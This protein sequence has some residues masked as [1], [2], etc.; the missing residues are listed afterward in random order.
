MLKK[1]ILAAIL[2]LAAVNIFSQT[3]TLLLDDIHLYQG[4]DPEEIPY[5]S[6]LVG[7]TDDL[8]TENHMPGIVLAGGGLDNDDAMKW[9]LNRADGGDVVVI[10]S[11]STD[12]YNNYLYSSLGVTVN[13]VETILINSREAAEHPYVEE[14]IRNAEALFIAGGDQYDYYEFWKDTPVMDA[15][16]Y[17]IKVF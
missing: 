4:A 14:Q 7:S 5:T 1:I 16:N 2:S 3:N 10:R 13:S 17:L 6:W 8:V 11:S 15:I 12:G 9:F